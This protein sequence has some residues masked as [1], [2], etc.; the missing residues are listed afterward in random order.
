MKRNIRIDKKY[1]N[2]V[3]GI[4]T[5]ATMAASITLVYTLMNNGFQQDFLLHIQ[6]QLQS[7]S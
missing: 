2:L 4:L 1:E 7:V 5:S 6:R 3:F